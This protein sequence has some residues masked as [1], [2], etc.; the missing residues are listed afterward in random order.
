MFKKYKQKTIYVYY[1]NSYVYIN[2]KNPI[3]IKLNIKRKA[4]NFNN[5][6]KHSFQKYKVKKEA[7]KLFNL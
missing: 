2:Q 1:I 6:K 7:M 5:S 4:L 3:V